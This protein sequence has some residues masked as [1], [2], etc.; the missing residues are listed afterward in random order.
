M[1]WQIM[2]RKFGK[3]KDANSF[4]DDAGFKMAWERKPLPGPGAMNYAYE[5]LALPPQSAISGAVAQRNFLAVVKPNIY[6]FQDVLL[7]GIPMVA[8]QT[9]L[10]PLYDPESGYVN[11]APIGAMPRVGMNVPVQFPEPIS[12][13]NPFPD[14]IG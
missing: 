7:N 8:G 1:A 6:K 4:Q 5:S 13:N 9:I 3:D 11:G 12:T 10:Q 14:R 2:G